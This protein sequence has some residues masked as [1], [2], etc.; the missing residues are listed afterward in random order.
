MEARPVKKILGIIFSILVMVVFSWWLVNLNS[1]LLVGRFLFVT[2]DN[3]MNWIGL[4][5]I[6]AIA[7]LIYNLYD[8]RRRFRGD[9]RSKSRID[10]MKNVRPLVANY[11]TDISNYMYF[12]YLLN[13]EKDEEK[14][15]RINAVLTERMRLIRSEYYQINLY[16]PRNDSNKQILDNIDLLYGELHNIGPYY[17]YGLIHSKIGNRKQTNY[18][19][20]VEEYISDLIN[21]TVKDGS[22]YFKKEWEKAKQGN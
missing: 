9:I 2:D 3:K 19:V 8:G 4:T 1:L 21:K 18:E 13:I 10:W 17:D 22:E 11:V 14:K 12:Y 15:Q 5:G 20:V 6:I 16:I 7:G